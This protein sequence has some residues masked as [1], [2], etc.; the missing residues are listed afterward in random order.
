MTVATPMRP[1]RTKGQPTGDG[2]FVVFEAVPVFDCHEGDDGVVY[3]E[4]L[5]R[6]IAS[7]CN[8]RIKTTGDWCPVV[9][10]H[11]RDRDE[12]A[13]ANDDPPVIGLAGPFWVAEFTNAQGQPSRAIYANFWIF[14]DQEQT[15]LRNPRRSVEIWPEERPENRFFDPISVLGAETP[16]RDL[17]M[18][19]SRQGS[20][21]V[22]PQRHCMHG[23][24]RYSKRSTGPIRYQEGGGVVS[25]PGGNNTFVP[26]AVD[27]TKKKPIQHAK[28]PTMALSPDDINQIIEALKPTIQAIVDESAQ[29]QAGAVDVPP[30]EGAGDPMGD[31]ASAPPPDMGD[32]IGGA[33][34]IAPQVDVPNYDDLDD[35]SKLYARGL[36]RKFMKYKKDDGWDDAGESAFMGTLDDDEQGKL[37]SYMKYMCDDEDTKERYA[38]RYAKSPIGGTDLTET[39]GDS[40]PSGCMNENEMKSGEP[41]KYQRGTTMTQPTQYARLRQERDEVASKY[42]KLNREHEELK[43]RY[44][45]Q[46]KDLSTLKTKERYSRRISTLKD[47]AYEYA[48]DPEE[49]MSLTEDY[50]DAQF[51]RHASTVIPSRYSRVSGSLLATERERP[52]TG[53]DKPQRYAKTAADL[54]QKYRKSGRDIDYGK[55]LNHL[56]E[57]DGQVNEERL[58]SANGHAH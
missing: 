55:V 3:D 56:I 12:K 13:H 58:F 7:N 1:Q 51:E 43:Q 47:L 26:S 23:P 9:V 39:S 14:P 35:E 4:Q 44:A 8:R 6:H 53:A 18:I 33:P 17:G 54:V 20:S 31:P 25:T 30:I 48:F 52:Q 19:Y 5:L 2:E 36:G 15:F 42:A 45:K 37:G 41:Q 21:G 49:E 50:S 11:T 29:N 27:L 10:A 38:Q 46:E 28:G 16:K 24:L 40:S 22:R 32:P 34:D 57:T